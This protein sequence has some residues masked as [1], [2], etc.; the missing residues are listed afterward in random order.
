[1]SF[2]MDNTMKCIPA[3]IGE[4]KQSHEKLYIQETWTQMDTF[5]WTHSR[6]NTGIIA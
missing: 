6:N 1:M 4:I 3:E 2:A 5:K